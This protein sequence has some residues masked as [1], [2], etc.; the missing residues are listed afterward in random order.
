[1]TYNKKVSC[2]NCGNT[3]LIE[4]LNLGEQ[5]LSGIFPNPAEK[6]PQSGPLILAKCD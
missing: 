4:F 6:D 5:P 1:M 2:R 3:D